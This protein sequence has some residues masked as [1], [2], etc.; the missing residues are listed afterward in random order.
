MTRRG[1]QMGQGVHWPPELV[2]EVALLLQICMGA[3]ASPHAC[4]CGHT[5]RPGRLCL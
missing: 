4:P 1:A 2:V 5:P 3:C